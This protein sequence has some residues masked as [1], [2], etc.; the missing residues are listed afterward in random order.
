MTPIDMIRSEFDRLL[1][2]NSRWDHKA[3]NLQVTD[4]TERAM[5]IQA[6]VSAANIGM[7]GDLRAEIREGLNSLFA[8][9]R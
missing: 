5:K 3:S 9:V 6:L 7:L 1:K 2:L 4:V 8:D